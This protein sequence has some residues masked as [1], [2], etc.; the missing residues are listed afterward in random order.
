MIEPRAR[1]MQMPAD[2]STPS[3]SAGW[4]GALCVAMLI[5]LLAL[6]HCVGH[7]LRTPI[8]WPLSAL[9]SSVLI[10]F[11]APGSRF[12]RP[13]ALIGGYGISLAVTVCVPALSPHPALTGSMVIVIVLI[14]VMMF[15]ALHPP[16][17]GFAFSLTQQPALSTIALA[18]CALL[19]TV[20]CV[21]MILF[22]PRHARSSI[23]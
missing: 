8:S 18:S 10:M 20:G 17:V 15:D 11:G 23:G 14:C 12:A 19:V 9:I 13:R 7:I 3:G 6:A 1:A 4:C 5:G 16:A 22:R 2:A 21:G